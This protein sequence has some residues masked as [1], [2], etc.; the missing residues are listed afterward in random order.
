[1]K[2]AQ[3][4]SRLGSLVNKRNITRALPVIIVVG[5]VLSF[6][7]LRNPPKELVSDIEAYQ[8]QLQS[9]VDTETGSPRDGRDPSTQQQSS[10]ETAASSPTASGQQGEQSASGDSGQAGINSS[11]CYYDYGE[12][13]QCVPA[14][15]ATGGTLTCEGVHSHGFP[16]GVKVVGEDRFKLDTNGDKMACA[17][18]D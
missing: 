10:L 13:D 8:D 16:N 17:T 2:L 7:L 15:A 1:M 6:V 3:V 9:Q 11:G 4:R 12:P 14:H 5:L 18:G